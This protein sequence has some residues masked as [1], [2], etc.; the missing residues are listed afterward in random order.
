MS[1]SGHGLQVHRD[2]L[3]NNPDTPFQFTPENLKKI[4]ALLSNFPDGHKVNYFLF[5][6]WF[7]DASLGSTLFLFFS[8][9]LYFQFLTWHNVK[10]DGYQF[11]QCMK[12]LEFW[13]IKLYFLYFFLLQKFLECVYM[14]Q[15]HFIQCII[16]NLLVNILFNCV[17]QLLVCFVGLKL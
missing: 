2:S 16:E 5:G 8:L 4:D 14:K 12:L 1:F 3:D 15:L 10:T 7:R 17:G 11:Q 9:Q 6:N 13:V